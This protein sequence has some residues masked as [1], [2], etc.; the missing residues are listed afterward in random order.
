MTLIRIPSL[1]FFARS[2]GNTAMRSKNKLLVGKLQHLGRYL[3]SFCLSSS[4]ASGVVEA[5]SNQFHQK[6]QIG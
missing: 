2:S 6:V 3:A 4:F 5:Y 1:S